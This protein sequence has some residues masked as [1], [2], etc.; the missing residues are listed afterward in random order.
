MLFVAIIVVVVAY[1]G[2]EFLSPVRFKKP[3]G[4]YK[5]GTSGMEVTD[6]TRIEDALPGEQR[7]RRLILQF[8]YPAE[9]IKGAETANYHP[10]PDHFNRDVKKLFSSIPQLL[11]KRLSKSKTN[12]LVNAPLSVS[13]NNYPV[14]V[15]SHGMDGMRFL[16]TFQMEEL[17][18]HGYIVVSIEHSFAASGTVFKDGSTGAVLPYELM[19]D[20]TFGNAIVNK[21]SADQVFVIN[22]L[23][24]LNQ[25]PGT[26]FSGKLN[27][28]ELGVFGFSFGGAVST[29]TLVLDKRI[30]AGVNLDGFYYGEN[31]SKGFEQ[32]FMEIRSQP[33]APEK[34]TEKELQM[35]HLT[36]ERW[37]YIWF[38]EWNKRLTS[39]AKN[40]YFSYTING[41]NHFSFCDLP[42]IA[43][44]KW[45]LAP[46]AGRIHDLTNQY[47]LAFFNKQL[48]GIETALLAEP[49]R[50]LK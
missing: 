41:A 15:F 21:W 42:L 50:T 8:W 31:Y 16:N 5:V 46:K 12:S 24:K 19:E 39:Y 29:N 38:D 48:K 36:R 37:K 14:L 11:L 1:A 9:K 17:A 34:V 30:K 20:E 6:T 32:P 23:E 4:P 45:L 18:S 22:Q 49:V 25:Q 33:A 47:T 10:N 44:F 26:M 13:E 35:S 28:K 7:S 43:P 2:F 40:G 27:M 3:S